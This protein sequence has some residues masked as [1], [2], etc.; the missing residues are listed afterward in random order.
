MNPEASVE[1]RARRYDVIVVGAGIAGSEAAWASARAGRDVLLVTTSL[2][3]VY[4]HFGDRVLLRPPEGTLMAAL[5]AAGA[6]GDGWIATRALHRA[7][8]AALESEAGLHLLQSSVTALRTTQGGHVLGVATWEG[9]ERCASVV[10]LCAGSFL[11]GRLRVGDL[12]ETAGRL[13]EMA[14]D[15]LYDDLL[16]RGLEFRRETVAAPA[17]AGALPYEVTFDAL[18]DGVAETGS[19]R[20]AA[21]PGLFAAGACARG[22]LSFEDAAAEGRSLGAAL[23]KATTS[24]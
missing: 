9:V 22:Y 16:R 19:G 12:T 1:G 10:A 15:E 3:T 18:A 4:N 14:Y 11:R 20:V 7:A 17:T 23:A 13:S 24:P 6:D 8:K 5:H 21:V 2:D